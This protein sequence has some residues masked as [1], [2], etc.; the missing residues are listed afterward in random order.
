LAGYSIV[1]RLIWLLASTLAGLWLLGSV[2][3]GLLTRFEVNERLDNALEEVAQR[4][5][6]ATAE[7]MQEPQ[8]M[9]HLAEQMVP[10]MDPRALAYQ[11]LS[12]TGRV[13]L[14]SPNA[15]EAPFALPLHPGFRDVRHYRVFT[16]P[17]AISAYFIEVAEPKMHRREALGRA[18]ALA[19]LPLLF[20]LP[21]SWLLIRWAVHR[22][23]R[24]LVA[25]QQEIS[26]RDGTN[27][28]RIPQLH[29]PAELVPIHMAINRL[30]DRLEHAL[31]HERQFA[32]NSAHELRTPI[33]ATLAQMQV[34][35]SQLGGTPHAERV[36]RIVSQV[37]ALGG[38][39]EKL[40][41][42]S[43]T[44]AGLALKREPTDLMPVL[45]ILTDDVRR[46]DGVGDRLRLTKGS[47]T[48]FIVWPTSMFWGSWFATCWKT[49]CCMARPM[50][51]SRLVSKKTIAFGCRTAVRSSPPMCWRC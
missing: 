22:S 30:L 6:P 40:L 45:Q 11:I 25:L 37:K 21:A 20:F 29:L 31:T 13:A 18:I 19:V 4:L 3:A 1:S 49:R 24:S 46:Q 26:E 15:P 7:A 38:L 44:G 17:S 12:A 42:L 48:E 41:Q 47:E 32:A 43:R 2:A 8:A 5:L 23:M 35:A 28:I 51:R 10:A 9:Q 16:R 14:R 39:T 27:L 33:A 50:R 34:L 36:S